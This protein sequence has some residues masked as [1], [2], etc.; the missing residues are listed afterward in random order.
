MAHLPKTASDADLISFV[1][2]WARLLEAEDYL[3][4]FA[5]TSH[6]PSMRWTPALVEQAIKSYDECNPSQKVTVEGKPT[7]VAQHK[8]VMRWPEPRPGGIG[9]IWYDLNIDGSASDLTATFSIFDGP[10]GL[11][12]QLEEISVM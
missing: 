6:D 11:T 8:E 5:F 3:G 4:A 7:D 2:D 1:D 10:E 12:V 9:L